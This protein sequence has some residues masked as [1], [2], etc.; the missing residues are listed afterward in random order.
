[1]TIDLDNLRS[2]LP[3]LSRRFQSAAPFPHIVIDD[4]LKPADAEA[5]L[6]EFR[7]PQKQAI[8]WRHYNENKQGL[9]RVDLMGSTIQKVI[10]EL[11][12]PDFIAVLRDLSGISG[13]RPDPELDGAGLHE[14]QRG[15]FLN[16]HVDFLSHTLHRSWSRQLNLL[17]YLNKDWKEKY[18]G[19]IEFWDMKQRR[20][21]HKIAPSFNRC[22]IFQTT[23]QAWHGY[24]AQLECPPETSRKS[25]ALY[26][27]REERAPL[28]LRPTF[29][30]YLP[31]DPLTK[32]ALI[33]ADRWALRLYSL[34]KRNSL[35]S[36]KWASRLLR[37]FQ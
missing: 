1:M 31:S 4:F 32:K 23:R 16:M 18:N 13:L 5:V 36:D 37:L 28:A 8:H 2:R 15:G 10:E 14:T 11:S 35:I 12:S 34:F 27:Y 20:Q 33:V 7:I 21:F 29:Y 22:V 25:I 19:Y 3:D 9:N 17:I 24:P 30:Q 26:Y 6:S